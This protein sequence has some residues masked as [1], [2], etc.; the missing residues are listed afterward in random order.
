MNKISVTALFSEIE[1][2]GG[3][4]AVVFSVV[5]LYV[6]LFFICN[7]ILSTF[8]S[9]LVEK[10]KNVYDDIMFSPRLM[11][12][13]ALLLPLLIM[14]LI[15]PASKI[16][17]YAR[18][19]SIKDVVLIAVVTTIICTVVDSL[20]AVYRRFEVSKH[21][22]VKG[23]AQ[24]VKILVWIA[25]VIFIASA[26]MGKSPWKLLA[27]LGAISA[28]LLMVFKDT[29]LGLT[30]SFQ[31]TMNDMIRVGDWI[32]LPGKCDGD[33]ID[34]SLH[35][36]KVQNWDKTISTVPTYSLINDSFVN[37]RGMSDSAGRRIKRS[38][39]I[40]VNTI[41]FCDAE[42]ISRFKKINLLKPYLREKLPDVDKTNSE[43]SDD[44]EDQANHRRLTNIGT[45]RAYVESYL[46][47]HPMVNQEMT[48][49]VRHLEPGKEGLPIEI[50]VFCKDK[51]WGNY[52][53]IQA[54]IFDHLLAILPEF[55][56][57]AFQNPTGYDFARM[58]AK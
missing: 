49:L 40:D 54:D 35:T 51:V 38:I 20:E 7:G 34:I 44:A 37:W 19:V 11:K 58:A 22:P 47:N 1:K 4:A 48:L 27:G 50:Y 56:L 6:V 52:E 36:V 42:A 53:A 2:A 12:Q 13:L 9:K 31:L 3:T 25:A 18:F 32:V 57:R 21:R 39:N 17:K 41:R 30:A 8:A 10:T 14:H 45:F 46:K 55:G 43:I 26:L 33:V 28:V 23:Y 24:L 15:I 5:C 29:I 16:A